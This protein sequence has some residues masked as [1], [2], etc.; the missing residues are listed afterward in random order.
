VIPLL[1]SAYLP[2]ISYINECIQSGKIILE[3]HEHYIK[4][5]YRNRAN[6]YSA[7]GMLALVIPV[8]HKNLFQIPIK[9][10]KISY[11]SSWQK[12]HWRSI[13]SAYRNSPFFEFLEDEFAPF[14][15]K[16]HDYLF[17]FNLLLLQKILSL[18]K[19][20]VEITFTTQY[21]KNPEGVKDLR[22]YFHPSNRLTQQQPYRQVFSERLGFIPDL[23]II[24]KLFNARMN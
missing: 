13:T 7:N 10:V 8:E 17:D 5:S 9:D 22:N 21:E 6:I 2:P 11:A 4:Q 1:S 19:G 15:E 24:D 14:Y 23:S 20:G 12:V 3:Q 18:M 16:K